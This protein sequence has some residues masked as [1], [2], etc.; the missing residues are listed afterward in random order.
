LKIQ[1]L[2][3]HDIYGLLD[4]IPKEITSLDDVLSDDLLGILNDDDT[5]LFDLK[6]VKKFE[7]RITPDFVARRKACKDFSKFEP[8]FKEVQSDL[9]SGKRILSNRFWWNW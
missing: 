4:Y 5:G 3:I 9:K 1:I 2:K 6:H 7:D 8:L